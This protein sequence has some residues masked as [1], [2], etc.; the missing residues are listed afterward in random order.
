MLIRNATV[1]LP[2]KLLVN[3]SVRTEGA[4]IAD[5]GTELPFLPGEPTV[6][7]SG[8][9]LAPGFVDLHIHLG[10]FAPRLKFGEELELSARNLP[11][12]G[13]TRYLPTL[14][15]AVQGLLPAQF[16]AV[17]DCMTRPFSGAQ[18]LGVH[19][20]GP[21]IAP[22][23]IGGFSPDQITTPERFSMK[24]ILDEGTDLVK[25]MML[26]PELPGAMP[27]IEDLQSRGIVAALGHTL[28]D[29]ATYDE[30]RS[31]GASHCTHTYN[32]R[33]TFPESPSGGRA[34]NLDDLA[35]ADDGVTCELI[36]DGVHVKPVWMKT[37]YR[38]KGADKLSLI[39]DS[40][41]CGQ[42][43]VEGAVFDIH[44]GKRLTVRGGVGRNDDGGLSGSVVTQDQALRRFVSKTGASLVDAVR[45]LTLSPA[46]VIGVDQRLGSITEG[47]IADIVLLDTGLHPLWTMVNGEVCWSEM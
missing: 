26:A 16:R 30:A 4:F 14:I 8:L 44:G 7:A 15:S 33:R 41:L 1:F 31:A 47:K 38:T 43:S 12:N 18:P 6:D 23:A 46:K 21:Y 25:L 35:V 29:E 32:N 11:R 36:A 17:R 28:A 34:F 22:G 9:Y 3:T 19:L 10:Y 27:V 45:S 20:E 39:T 37:I 5:V 40:F 24:G 13:T 42:R 2:D